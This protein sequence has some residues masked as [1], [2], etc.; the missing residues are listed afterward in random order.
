MNYEKA[1]I[2]LLRALRA[3]SS[4][5]QLSRK[6]G[7]STNVVYRWESGR[8]VP[9]A[10][11]FFR[12]AELAGL[13]P[14]QRLLDAGFL[15][16]RDSRL[17]LGSNRDVAAWLNALRGELPIRALAD[18]THQSRFVLSRWFSGATIVRLPDL[19][20]LLDA[21]T[22]RGLDFVAGFV[23]P[24]KLPSVAKEW[25]ALDA[26]REAALRHPWSHAVLRVLELEQYR[27]LPEHRRGFI[28]TVLGVSLK[29][30]ETCLQILRKARQIKLAGKR[31]VIDQ[32]RTLD[33]RT[34]KQRAHDPRGFWIDVAHQ[35][36]ERQVPGA[37]SYNI[38]SLSAADYERLRMLYRRFFSEMQ[39]LVAR[40]A[41]SECV[42][43][44]CTQMVAFQPP[45]HRPQ[46]RSR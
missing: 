8:T 3:R 38:C 17:D 30:E 36:W 10:A 19:L 25:A 1:A 42:A 24:L 39:E 2:E 16:A 43:L 14:K 4:Q 33:T 9:A 6:L 29:E 28:A 31:W 11:E 37:Y 46:T 22:H 20:L 27:N 26:S 32:Q 40:S 34:V 23:D 7:F 21:M 12:L 5:R 44:I 15:D 13:H 35:S 18:S 41:P 45:E